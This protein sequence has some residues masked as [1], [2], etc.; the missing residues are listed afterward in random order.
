MEES[1]KKADI[2][3]EALP[4]I[5]RFRGKIFVI[6][7]GGSIFGDERVREAVLEDMLFLSFVGIKII[8]VHGGG[9]NISDRL[10]KEGKKTD[11]YEGMRVTDEYTLNVVKEELDK[12]N[13][14]V[15][16]ELSHHGVKIEGISGEQKN[17]IKAEKK[18]AK[19]NLGFV[20]QVASIGTRQIKELLAQDGI[21]VISPMG[22]GEGKNIYNINADEAAE[23]IAS[24]LK[25]EKFVLFTNVKGIMRDSTNPESLIPS[26]TVKEVNQLIKENIIQSGMIPKV[27]ACVN[28][29]KSGVSKTHIIDAKLPHALLLEI[30]TDKGIGTEI[31]Q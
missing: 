29:L 2:L 19:K 25:A 11:F 30:F 27:K 9:P 13:A 22:K 15:V 20:G 28:A 24:S 3:I 7:Y 14:Q 31:A 8:L 18:K 26:L 23:A 10:K 12:L 4:Y 16:K 21:V 1:I 6:K 5:K 17:I